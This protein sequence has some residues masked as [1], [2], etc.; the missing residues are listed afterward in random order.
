MTSLADILTAAQSLPSPERAQLIVAL[1]DNISPDDWVP[2]SAE[3]IAEANR[4]SDALDAGNMTS[5]EWSEVRERARRK[6]G[7][8]G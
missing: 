1:W 3:W 8:D 7:L 5:A 6:A 2:P 4:R